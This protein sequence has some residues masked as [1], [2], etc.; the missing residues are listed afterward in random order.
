M[1]GIKDMKKR[2]PNAFRSSKFK[3][4]MHLLR[5]AVL[6]LNEP[7]EHGAQ[8]EAFTATC[9]HHHRESI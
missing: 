1:Q 3:Y 6:S 9:H 5:V 7:G 8:Y 4:F 2:I